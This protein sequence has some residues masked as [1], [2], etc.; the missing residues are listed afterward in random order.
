MKDLKMIPK[1]NEDN[2][3][4]GFYI[5][6]IHNDEVFLFDATHK[7]LSY[8]HRDIILPTIMSGT[9]KELINGLR[10]ELIASIKE[11]YNKTLM[12]NIFINPICN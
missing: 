8:L 11:L 6:V 9:D 2:N 10:G 4:V 12:E 3:F 5:S 1:Y 7:Y